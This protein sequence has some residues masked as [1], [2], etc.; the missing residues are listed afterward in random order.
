MKQFFTILKFELDNYFKSKSYVISTILIAVLAA[1]IMFVPRVKDAI[2]GD[3]KDS[4]VQD[5]ASKE[6]S[7]AE[8]DAEHTYGVYDPDGIL[9]IDVDGSV[10]GS[11]ETGINL[12]SF[13]SEDALKKAVEEEEAAAGFAV[14]SL[15]DYDYYVYNKSMDNS[16]AAV[17]DGYLGML[18]KLDYCEKHDLDLN[19][20]METSYKEIT[21]DEYVLGKDST[22]NFWYC[23]VL[24]IL[25]FML[26]IM[27]GMSIASSVTNEKS[28][29]SIEILVTSTDSTALLFG[30]V[31]AGA[32][33]TV[34]QVGIIA[35]CLLGSYQYNKDF[36][37]ID[38]GMFLDIPAN[39]LVV[40]AVFGIGGFLFYAF[41]YGALGALV[42]KIEDLNKSAGSAQMII[43]IVYFVVLLQLDKVDGVPMKVCSF[44][45]FSSYSAMFARVAMGHVQ[46]WEIIVSAVIL[47]ISVALMGVI[48][49]KIFR[50]STLR[51][52]NPIKLTTAIKNLRKKD[53]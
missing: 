34:F 2:T 52:G 33:A 26:I 39:V 30:K 21:H 9:I 14:H 44:L 1:G 50:S 53:S 48:G 51:Y 4:T 24:V 19:E 38:L 40:F 3:K 15:S 11:M 47:Y 16:D 7:S 12:V 20:F 18:V 23:Y 10:W 46:T 27:Y 25:I 49:G 43:M 42:S 13:D 6:D 5:S 29:R 41:L 45:P 32:V 17:F 22:Q 28:N 8:A 31:F 37:G 35:V 36:W